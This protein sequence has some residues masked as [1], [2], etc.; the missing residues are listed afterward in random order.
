MT[1]QDKNQKTNEHFLDLWIA[2]NPVIDGIRKE[3]CKV[4]NHSKNVQRAKIIRN[5][6]I[7]KQEYKLGFDAFKT[8][9]AALD[10]AEK[11]R[12]REINR[13]LRRIQSIELRDIDVKDFVKPE[14]ITPIGALIES[15]S[16]Q[17][18]ENP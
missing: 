12:E 18:Y 3:H 15:N 9:E 2:A 10:Y 4:W 11:E 8:K 13:L 17:P 16:Y 14:G 7:Y 1:N 5:G 6:K